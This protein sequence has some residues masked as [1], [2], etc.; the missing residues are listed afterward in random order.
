MTIFAYISDIDRLIITQWQWNIC[1]VSQLFFLKKMHNK[2]K[3][4]IEI[5]EIKIRKTSKIWL[6]INVPLLLSTISVSDALNW[7]MKQSWSCYRKGTQGY[8]ALLQLADWQ[9]MQYWQYDLLECIFGKITAIAGEYTSNT[10][11]NTS[12]NWQNYFKKSLLDVKM[13]F[14]VCIKY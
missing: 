14:F 5:N 3:D 9:W 6:T 12:N 7:K 8:I 2:L 10:S 1:E 4:Y 13:T 11:N